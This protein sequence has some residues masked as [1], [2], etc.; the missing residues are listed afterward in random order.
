MRYPVFACGAALA[1]AIAFAL[2][3][4]GAA[5]AQ[6][7][8]QLRAVFDLRFDCERPFLVRG[9]PIRATFDAVLRSDKTAN[10]DLAIR[11]RFF[12]N[13]VHFDAR[14]GGGPRPAPGGT[15]LLRVV[16]GNHLR[17]VWDLPNNQLVLDIISKGRSCA[18][19]LAMKLKPGK[20]DYTMYD[21]RTFYYCSAQK[22][23]STSCEAR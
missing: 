20:R 19:R 15:S 12:T 3:L 16:S 2:L 10:A 13:T 18:A 11:G 4:P 9:H 5:A 8:A 21:G 1:P 22:L 14:L 6:G 17:G 7:S 23:L